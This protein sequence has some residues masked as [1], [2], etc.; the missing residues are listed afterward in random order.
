M[1]LYLKDWKEARDFGDIKQGLR[2]KLDEIK[3][4][5]FELK[6]RQDGPPK[7]KDVEIVLLGFNKS[8]LED[9]IS[10]FKEHVQALPTFRDVFTN[11]DQEVLHWSIDQN[12]RESGLSKVDLED[13][14][15]S[16]MLSSSGGFKLGERN[17][18]T[19]DSAVD[20]VAKTPKTTV[21]WVTLTQFALILEREQYLSQA[22]LP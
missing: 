20:V 22:F 8:T 6:K 9:A 14:S 13:I 15:S 17:T 12:I 18:N 4:L 5:T 7:E 21:P 2:A 1:I 19:S 10:K 11:E 16:I 3:G